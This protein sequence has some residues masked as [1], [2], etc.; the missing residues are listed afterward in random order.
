MEGD[1]RPIIFYHVYSMG[2]FGRNVIIIRPTLKCVCFYFYF[3]TK[4][5]FFLKI[6]ENILLIKTQYNRSANSMAHSIARAMSFI[7]SP[8]E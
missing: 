8:C 7:S 1:H 4:C 2:P 5:N 6:N 3:F